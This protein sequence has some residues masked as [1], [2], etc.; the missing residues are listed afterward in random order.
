MINHDIF[1]VQAG[2]PTIL[3]S[4]TIQLHLCNCKLYRFESLF[5]LNLT[6]S[7]YTLLQYHNYKSNSFEKLYRTMSNY[8]STISQYH[9]PK[10]LRFF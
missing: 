2:A 10:H 4:F 1:W 5:I 8:T 6:G 3:I 7:N 9:N